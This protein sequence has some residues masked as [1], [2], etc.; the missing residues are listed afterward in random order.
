MARLPSNVIFADVGER[1]SYGIFP[2][3]QTKSTMD[4]VVGV[5]IQCRVRNP[6]AVRCMELVQVVKCIHDYANEL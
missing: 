2:L 1:V 6:L 4:F 5:T 3:K